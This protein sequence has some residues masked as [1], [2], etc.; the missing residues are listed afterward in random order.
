M[1]SFFNQ[2]AAR[3]TYYLSSMGDAAAP[4]GTY[5]TRKEAEIAMTNYCQAHDIVVEC[6]EDDKHSKLYSDHLGIS[7]CINRL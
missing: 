7:F 2:I 6:V 4:R 1:Y 5:N 3:H